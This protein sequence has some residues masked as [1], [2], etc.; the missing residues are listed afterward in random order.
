MIDWQS[1]RELIWWVPHLRRPRFHPP[2]RSWTASTSRDGPENETAGFSAMRD[3][4]LTECK[5]HC[6]EDSCWLVMHGKVYEVTKFLDDHPGGD[7]IMLQAAGRDA[8]DDFEDVGHSEAARRQ[9]EPM[10]IGTFVDDGTGSKQRSKG[11]GDAGG[12]AGAMR[13]LLPLLILVF[14]YLVRV[15]TQGEL[16]KTSQ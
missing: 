13:F 15:L 16:A 10:L 9:L 7:E 12:L 14:A 6:S 2:P 1:G 4:T 11:S 8:T 5:E 3:I